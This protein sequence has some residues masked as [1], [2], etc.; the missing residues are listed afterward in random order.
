MI[1]I[2]TPGK[3]GSTSV[4]ESLCSSE[5]SKGYKTC[6]SITEEPIYH[7]HS[8]AKE[9]PADWKNEH[10]KLGNK[11]AQLYHG[12]NE[13]NWKF[14]MGVRD[15]IVTLISAYYQNQY[16]KKGPLLECM[17]NDFLPIHMS[18]MQ[19]FISSVYK[20]ELG[21]N[22][23]EQP[24]D[25]EKGYSIFN[26]GKTSTL[27][28]R[29]DKLG[30]IFQEAIEKFL[31]I[32]NVTLLKTHVTIEKNLNYNGTSIKDSYEIAKRNFKLPKERVIEIYNHESVRHFFTE[33]EIARFI[34]KW[35]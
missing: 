35:S 16:S 24:F 25:K 14:I 32:S 13:I 10:D 9:L 12:Q 2:L 27:I 21:I 1:I 5:F 19:N 6:Y 33:E 23:Y 26:Q 30:L 7:L 3:V 4:L 8:I 15:P 31:N 11:I 20:T 28:Y 22:L 34:E 17:D 18:W 29:L